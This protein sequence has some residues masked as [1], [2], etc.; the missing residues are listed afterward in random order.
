MAD[1]R[2]VES[3]S[4]TGA[5]VRAKLPGQQKFKHRYHNDRSEDQHEAHSHAVLL[6]FGPSFRNIY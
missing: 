1:F 4:P 5:S 2:A 3:A 6:F